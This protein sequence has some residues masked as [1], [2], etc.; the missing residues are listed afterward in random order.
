MRDCA[1]H[2]AVALRR[3]CPKEGDGQPRTWGKRDS[4]EHSP[5]ERCANGDGPAEGASAPTLGR[6]IASIESVTGRGR[7]IPTKSSPSSSSSVTCPPTYLSSEFA[8][9]CIFPVG[10]ASCFVQNPKSWHD[11]LPRSKR[12]N[13]WLRDRAMWIPVTQLPELVRDFGF[14][15]PEHPCLAGTLF[16]SCRLIRLAKG[17]NFKVFRL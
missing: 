16:A 6:H 8:P 5:G 10:A 15:G 12:K 9:I 2:H 17:A 13:D 4:L 3:G 14:Q 1:R 11:L 7:S